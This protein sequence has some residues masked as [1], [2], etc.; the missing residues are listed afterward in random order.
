MAFFNPNMG[1]G[2]KPPTIGGPTRTPKKKICAQ[3]GGGGR[4]YY[5]LS[6]FGQILPL[7]ALLGPFGP[8]LG[9]GFAPL[10]PFGAFWA[11]F[12]PFWAVLVPL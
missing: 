4:L 12:G 2:L 11:L 1:T 6:Y 5:P 7:W 10:G 9:T 3:D 8:F